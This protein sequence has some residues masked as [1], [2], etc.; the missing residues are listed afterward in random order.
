[1]QPIPA[2]CRALG[3]VAALASALTACQDANGPDQSVAPTARVI[4]AP[5]AARN[6]VAD[7]YVVVFNDDVSDV[8]GRAAGLANAHGGNVQHTFH[9]ALKGFSAHM[10]AQAAEAIAQTP[11]VAYVEPNQLFQLASTQSYAPWGLDRI[12]QATW[13]LDGNYNYSATGAGVNAYIID[14]GIRLT[15]VD[16]GGRAVAA[17]SSIDDGLG[18][19]ATCH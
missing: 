14:A 6:T 4:S 17:Y 9:R 1:M 12:D 8:D 7:E 10:S 3:A 16:F 2:A 11:G 19:G 18:A 13:P 5:N 15:H